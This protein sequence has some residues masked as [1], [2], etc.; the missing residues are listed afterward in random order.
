MSNEQQTNRPA[1]ETKELETI[2][3]EL[4]RATHSG[5]TGEQRRAATLLPIVEH[6]LAVA[7]MF[8]ASSDFFGGNLKAPDTEPV[9]VAEL[10]EENGAGETASAYPTV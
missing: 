6:C 5:D 1:L 9:T 3:D 10:S 7:A 4:Q 8:N 2:R